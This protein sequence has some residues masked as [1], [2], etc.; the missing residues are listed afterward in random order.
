MKSSADRS[1]GEVEKGTPAPSRGKSAGEDVMSSS[2]P[3]EVAVQGRIEE[4]KWYKLKRLFVAVER[5]GL[6]PVP[7]V[8][9]TDRRAFSLFT[10][11]FSANFC[12]LP[13][14]VPHL[15]FRSQPY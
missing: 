9:Q 13:Y 6:E 4:D 15:L 8:E 14:V 3:G 5:R 2:E 12:L 11:W 7:E 1:L 10:L